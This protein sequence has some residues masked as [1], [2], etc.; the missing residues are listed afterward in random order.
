MRDGLEGESEPIVGKLGGRREAGGGRRIVDIVGEMGQESAF[1]I[2]L[3]G[4]EERLLHRHVGGMRLGPEGVDDEEVEVIEMGLRR[5]GNGL[6]V[7]DISK[8]LAIGKT[9]TKAVGGRTA[10]CDRERHDLNV[11]ELEE[12]VVLEDTGVRPHVI[13]RSIAK[14]PRK[15]ALESSQGVVGPVHRHRLLAP[16]AKGPGLVESNDVIDVVVGVEDVIDVGEALPQGL[17]PKVRP[18]INEDFHLGCFQKD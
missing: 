4:G 15:H 16:P 10:M 7:G 5:P 1:R 12:I 9:E 14:S 2:Q 11:A 18:S 8:T 6:H 17:L 13:A 3:A